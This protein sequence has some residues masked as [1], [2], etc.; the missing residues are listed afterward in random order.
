MLFMKTTLLLFLAKCRQMQ[1]SQSHDRRE[2][3]KKKKVGQPRKDPSRIKKQVGIMLTPD[4]QEF[5]DEMAEASGVSKST[6][7]ELLIRQA[8][9]R[10]ENS[11]E[12][13]IV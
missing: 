2:M 10:Y 11:E 6:F 7:V 3:A 4:S 8:Y 5:L 12:S 1:E 13:F 9:R